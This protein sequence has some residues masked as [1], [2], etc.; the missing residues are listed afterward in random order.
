MAFTPFSW[1]CPYCGRPTTITEP[2]YYSG[3][4]F[5]HLEDSKFGKVGFSYAGISCPNQTCK[6]LSFTVSLQKAKYRHELSNYVGRD[7]LFKWP[8]L[9]ESFAKPQPDY[10]PKTI[11]D[12]YYEAC[13]IRDLSPKASATLSRRCLQGMI[14]H[15]WEVRDQP[16]LA[17]E[18]DAIEDKVDQPTW[19]AIDGVRQ[20]GNIGAHMEKDVDLI[21]DVDPEE[22]QMLISLIELLFANWYIAKHD[23]DERIAKVTALAAKKKKAKIDATQSAEVQRES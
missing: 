13:R 22:A 9:P 5:L 14:R 20:V 21:I 12:D 2:H 23:S 7:V 6:E 17:K 8:L 16:T 11:C 15:F 1:T 3:F 10:I 4:R 19:Q 18:I